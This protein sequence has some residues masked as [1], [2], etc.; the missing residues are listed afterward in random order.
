MANYQYDEGGGMAS[1]FLLTFLSLILFPLTFSILRPS[2]GG[3]PIDRIS[4]LLFTDR[5]VLSSSKSAGRRL[6]M[7]TLP[8]A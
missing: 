6:S 7:C 1:Y 5:S 4:P 3:R 8:R 2:A